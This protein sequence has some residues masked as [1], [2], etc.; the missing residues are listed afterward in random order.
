MSC[1]QCQVIITDEAPY[2]ENYFGVY[3]TQG[4]PPLPPSQNLILN[5]PRQYVTPPVTPPTNPPSPPG[6]VPPP[7]IPGPPNDDPGTPIGDPNDDAPTGP[8]T[9]GNTSNPGG[10]PPP[11]DTPNNPNNDEP[12][13]RDFGNVPVFF[14][15]CTGGTTM[16]FTGSTP[17]WIMFNGTSLEGR[18][19]VFRGETQDLANEAAQDALDEFAAAAIANGEL[20]CVTAVCPALATTYPM[21]T[22]RACV[23]NPVTDRIWIS[24]NVSG[25]NI[26]NPAN[27]AAVTVTPGTVDELVYASTPN[28]VFA[29]FYNG[30][31]YDVHYLNAVTGADLGTLAPNEFLMPV[32]NATKNHICTTGA[33]P[34]YNFYNASSLALD[35]TISDIPDPAG[36]CP[37]YCPTT[38]KY[39]IGSDGVGI[40]VYNGDTGAHETTI[41]SASTF[42]AGVYAPTSDRIVILDNDGVND[43]AVFINPNTN[44]ITDT[45]ILAVVPWDPRFSCF[46]DPTTELIY[47]V[48]QGDLADV[49]D[50]AAIAYLCQ[51]VNAGNFAINIGFATSNNTVWIN[52][53]FPGEVNVFQ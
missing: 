25:I 36:H 10:P 14:N 35:F 37:A 40:R 17:Q 12:E 2:L 38:N 34:V 21:T 20:T 4:R 49:I 15:N 48:G 47:V 23:Y 1:K 11:P 32:Y 44:T 33:G 28:L 24:R 45:I 42:Y 7:E 52:R 9:G 18:E 3:A 27:G 51:L 22:P 16:Q 8:D 19:G 46:I 39:Y 26:T 30:F 29:S 41:V 53:N 5:G 31:G 50:S 43:R 13:V 6:P